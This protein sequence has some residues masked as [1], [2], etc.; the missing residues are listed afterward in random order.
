[1]THTSQISFGGGNTVM[2]LVHNLTAYDTRFIKKYFSDYLN[3]LLKIRT[4]RL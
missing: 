3:V 4:K 1:M 2:S